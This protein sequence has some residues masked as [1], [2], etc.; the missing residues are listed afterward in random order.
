MW[1]LEHSCLPPN[2]PPTA[3]PGSALLPHDP[4]GT[5]AGSPAGN[6]AGCRGDREHRNQP[7]GM[8][9]KGH[10]CAPWVTAN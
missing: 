6:R 8:L 2:D 1:L 3:P 10:T 5:W 4:L 7:K 9:G